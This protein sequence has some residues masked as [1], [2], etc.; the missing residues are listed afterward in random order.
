MQS[1]CGPCSPA[2]QRRIEGEDEPVGEP[3]G[4]AENGPGF[5]EVAEALSI[6]LPYRL[7]VSADGAERR[8][9]HFGAASESLL[10][11]PAAALV[12]DP[13]RFTAI[14]LPEERE[15]L[16]AEGRAI[17]ASRRP[18]MFETR[19]RGADG[20][21]RWIRIRSAPRPTSDGG[22]EWNGLITDVTDAKRLA[23][24]LAEEERRVKLTTELTGMGFFEWDRDDPHHVRLS[25]IEYDICGLPRGSD[26]TL[27]DFR[28]LIHPD[29]R[30]RA[31]EAR[32][33]ASGVADASQSA[34]EYRIVRP[35]GALR[36]VLAHMRVRRDAEGMKS[37]HGSML[38]ITER[39][40]A[41][42]QRRLQLREMS[43]RG[44][45]AIAVMMAM[46]QQSARTAGSA[47]ELAERLLARLQAMAAS[48]DLATASEGRPLPLPDLLRRALAA[49]DLARFELDASLD[50]ETVSSEPVI[51]LALLLHEL[52]TN[53]VKYGALSVEAGRVRL[54]RLAAP[55]G[56]LAVEW[57]EVGGPKVR[58]PK[59]EGF[60]TRLLAAALR[61]VGGRVE[62]VFAPDGFV[63]RLEMPA[64]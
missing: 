15:R 3:G 58:P 29:D 34:I 62:P 30:E 48:Q 10:G 64:G 11:L 45:N 54:S 13:R 5:A 51:G 43:H 63:A 52:A 19:I 16:T 27:R 36:W 37:L 44:K 6:G 20:E 55:P 28:E 49:F 50:G 40:N 18:A 41:E 22:C 53:S 61:G 42:E 14:V 9:L 1:S 2:A 60:G 32:R 33:W 24:Q 23:E 57:R 47:E 25:D 7:W 17:L 46:V 31:A 59:R 8:F 56:R 38:D 39:R 21:V 26:V 12:A 4:V 35:D